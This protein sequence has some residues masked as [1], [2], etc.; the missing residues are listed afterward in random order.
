MS[1]RK[2]KHNHT[3]CPS[4][5]CYMSYSMHQV[6][7]L[8]PVMTWDSLGQHTLGQLHLKQLVRGNHRR[9]NLQH[10]MV[11][12]WYKIIATGQSTSPNNHCKKCSF[13]RTQRLVNTVS[14]SPFV[15]IYMFHYTSHA[16]VTTE[17]GQVVYQEV[18]DKYIFLKY[19]ITMQPQVGIY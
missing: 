10:H 19:H 4:M 16:G 5:I 6:H 2:H 18:Y 12:A 1:S 9:I 14:V 17:H 7:V 11:N 3:Q 8:L 13:K 15:R